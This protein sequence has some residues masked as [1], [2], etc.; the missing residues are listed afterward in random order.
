MPVY[1][2]ECR[3]CG[4]K[5]EVIY[6][7]SARGEIDYPKILRC[8]KCGRKTLERIVSVPGKRWRYLDKL[9]G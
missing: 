4:N 6:L 9:K 1:E 2:Y 3:V 8:N 5:F 7:P